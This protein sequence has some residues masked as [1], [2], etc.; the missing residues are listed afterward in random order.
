MNLDEMN[1][2]FYRNLKIWGLAGL[3]IGMGLG[4]LLIKAG[5]L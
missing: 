1:A 2:R 5:I 4:Y 3:L